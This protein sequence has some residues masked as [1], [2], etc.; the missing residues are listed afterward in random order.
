[1]QER[2]RGEGRGLLE[3][4]VGPEEPG[5]QVVEE[6][7]QQP[8]KEQ[9]GNSLELEERLGKPERVPLDMPL[10]PV[11]LELGLGTAAVRLELGLG[12]TPV[13]LES[14]QE[15]A[16]GQG[17]CDQ[18]REEHP[19]E[20]AHRGWEAGPPQLPQLPPLPLPPPSSVEAEGNKSAPA[21]S[22]PLRVHLRPQ[23]QL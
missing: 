12:T 4:L 13:R 7:H 23:F 22:A 14:G 1:M 15:A 18:D 8:Q 20:L 19:Q 5:L 16:V 10:V 11:L 6:E 3:F 9:E 21:S 2:H 17:E